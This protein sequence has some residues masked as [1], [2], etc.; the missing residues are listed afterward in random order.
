ML[1]FVLPLLA[2]VILKVFGLVALPWWVILS[3][4]WL[5]TLIVVV[6]AVIILKNRK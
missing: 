3:P 6:L 2:L 5:E 1:N 4:L